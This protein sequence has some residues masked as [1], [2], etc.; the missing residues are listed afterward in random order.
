MIVTDLSRMYRRQAGS[1]SRKI[2]GCYLTPGFQA[3]RVYRLGHWL[4]RQPK[5]IRVLLGPISFYL[6]Y[7]MGEKWGIHISRFTPIG[8]GFLIIH[9]GGIFI[10]G[11]AIGKNFTIYNDTI[12]GIGGSGSRQGFP[13]IGDNVQVAPGAK[14]VGKLTIGNNVR[15]GPNAV[16]QID[17]SD[18]AV[19][20]TPPSRVVT[21]PSLYGQHPPS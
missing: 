1:R 8:Q 2:L 3:V 12:V 10:G 17:V 5:L 15:I 20:Q 11:T 7:K 6:H 14:I 19:V 13:V 4:L 21:F 18:N 16:V 9:Y